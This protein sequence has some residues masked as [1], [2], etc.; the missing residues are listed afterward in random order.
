MAF[1]FDTFINRNVQKI[2]F[3]VELALTAGNYNF[4]KTEKTE[5]GYN[6]LSYKVSQQTASLAPQLLYNL[7]NKDTFKAYVG[8]G[9]ILNYSNYTKNKYT[10]Q[11]INP[12]N[13]TQDKP[14]EIN[15]YL[16]FE[17]PWA[18]YTLRTGVVLHNKY[19]VA[20]SYQPPADITRYMTYAVEYSSWAI[21]F[22]YLFIK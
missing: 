12:A 4:R 16:K 22:N 20:L 9:A 15:N 2:V 17:S 21:G 13:N 10:N 6:E 7:Y 1:G 8:V 18:Y 14:V 11:Y 5:T 19:E 3:R